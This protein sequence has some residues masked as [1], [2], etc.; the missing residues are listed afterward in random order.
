MVA[1]GCLRAEQNTKK[2]GDTGFQLEFALLCASS[3]YGHSTSATGRGPQATGSRRGRRDPLPGSGEE[4]LEA[5]RARAP[6]RDAARGRAQARNVSGPRGCVFSQEF[7]FCLIFQPYLD[8]RP[9]QIEG[10]S[11]SFTPYLG[12]IWREASR[13]SADHPYRYCKHLSIF[14]HLRPRPNILT[15]VPA[16]LCSGQYSA[17][18]MNRLRST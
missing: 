13:K 7:G 11:S 5:A 18:K 9:V 8:S 14:S 4:Q 6:S 17:R 3:A 15:R 12:H 10:F 2:E 1:S 16:L